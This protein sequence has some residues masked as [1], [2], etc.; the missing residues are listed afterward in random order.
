MYHPFFIAFGLIPV[1]SK[2]ITTR[3]GGSDETK[4]VSLLKA[5]RYEAELE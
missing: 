4:A 3:H 1:A 2:R 5:I